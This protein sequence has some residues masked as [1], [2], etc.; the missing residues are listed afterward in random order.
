MIV[1]AA[2]K[3]AAVSFLKFIVFTCHSENLQI[4]SAFYLIIAY[5]ALKIKCHLKE[6]FPKLTVRVMAG[7]VLNDAAAEADGNICGESRK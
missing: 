6:R 7:S 4:I 3:V 5:R 2:V 1:R